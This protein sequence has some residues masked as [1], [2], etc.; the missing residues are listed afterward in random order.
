M[1]PKLLLGIGL[2]EMNVQRLVN[3]K[4][5]VLAGKL[6]NVVDELFGLPVFGFRVERHLHDD[7]E[8]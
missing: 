4:I 1:L 7:A 5:A 3:P 6:Q 8:R 2:I